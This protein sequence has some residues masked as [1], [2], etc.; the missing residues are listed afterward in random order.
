M[1]VTASAD[2]QKLLLDLQAFDTKLIQLAHKR[3]GL[4]EIVAAQDLEVE[5]GAIKMRLVRRRAPSVR[6]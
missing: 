5:L 1:A 4:P 6:A 3:A 2:Q